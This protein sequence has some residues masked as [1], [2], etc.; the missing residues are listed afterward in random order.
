M[1]VSEAII[2][3]KAPDEIVELIE[4]GFQN[5][6]IRIAKRELDTGEIKFLI[7]STY[8]VLSVVSAIFETYYQKIVGKIM[9]PGG[10]EY[11]ITEA[12]LSEFKRG[13]IEVMT[14]QRETTLPHYPES[15]PSFWVLYKDEVGQVIT[16]LPKWVDKWSVSAAAIKGK[17]IYGIFGLL[18]ATLGVV[19]WLVLENRISGEALV[20]LAGTI[21]GYV[22]AFL[23]KYLGITQTTS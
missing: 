21:I 7:P 11:E 8:W 18:L 12:G 15:E 17:V 20:F 19:T 13:L 10:S 22:F 23:Q 4:R 5:S 16:N 3:I 1:S 2:I 9:T 6:G 14:E